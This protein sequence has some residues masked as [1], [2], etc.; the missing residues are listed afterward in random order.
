VAEAEK[1]QADL[2]IEARLAAL[3]ARVSANK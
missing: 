3:K 2:D 1:N